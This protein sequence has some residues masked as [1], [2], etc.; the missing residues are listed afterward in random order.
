MYHTMKKSFTLLSFFCFFITCFVE[1]QTQKFYT[2]DQGLSNSLIN[3]IYQDRK[4]FVW[5][6]T[7]WGLNK[8]DGNKFTVYTYTAG[9]ANSLSD[10]YVRSI[11]EDR[12]GRLYVGLINGLMY[13]DPY[14]D[15]FVAVKMYGENQQLVQ[16]H[17][18]AMVEQANGD[19]IIA[20]SGK[21][22]FILRK[23]KNF[24]QYYASLS[25]RLN[26]I[27]IST[28]YQDRDKNLWIA[29]E[30]GGL[31][32]F[33]VSTNNLELISAHR[34]EIGENV[35][36]IVEDNIGNVF[37]GTL[38]NGLFIYNKYKKTIS[39]AENSTGLLVK[40]L[41]LNSENEL[42]IGT[43]GQG[44]K[45]YDY[46]DNKI[47]VYNIRTF[48][49]DITNA[50]V[51]SIVE[52]LDK[53]L[54]LGLFQKGVIFLSSAPNRFNYWGMKQNMN[55]PIGQG[56]VMS[57]FKDRAGICWV[58]VDN[59]GLYAVDEN[60][61]MIHHYRDNGSPNSVSNIIL[62]IFE[63]R[64]GN[65]WLGSFTS[66]LCKIDKNTGQCVY[67]PRLKG[68]KVYF[69]TEDKAGDLLVATYG[70][71]FYRINPQTRAC[72]QFV[73]SKKENEDYKANELSNDWINVLLCD[74]DGIIWVGHHKGLS[75]YN[76]RKKTFVN[77]LG[78]N[79][80]LPNMV[81]V[82]LMEASDGRI[83]VGTTDGFVIFDKKRSNLVKYTSKD[84]LPNN[85]ICGMKEDADGEVWISTYHGLS[86]FSPR[87]K[88]FVNYYIDDG[89][90]GYEFTRGASFE[91]A[92]GMIYFGGT[93]GL[94]FF[95]PAS[96]ISQQRTL[97]LLLTDLYIGN[98]RAHISRDKLSL[99]ITDRPIDESTEFILEDNENSFSV[100]L[101]TM[102][103]ANSDR[104]VYQY[105]LEGWSKEWL[106]TLPGVNRVSFTNLPSGKYV[107]KV[108]AV[109]NNAMSPERDFI[110]RILPPWYASWWAYLGYTILVLIA[111]NGVYKYYSDKMHYKAELREQ[112]K[113]REANESRLQYFIN[114]S[115]E[116]RTPMSLIISP[117]EKLMAANSNPEVHKSYLIIHRN[118]SR[119]LRLIN[120]LMDVRKLDKGQMHLKCRKTDIVG[121]IK[122][123]ILTF[124]YQ[125]KKK[126][127]DFIFYYAES[128][129]Y[130]WIDLNNFDKV[131]LNLFSNAFK[132]TP[133]G[134]KIEV[135]LTLGY[136]PNGK[137]PL[138]NYFQ[139]VV[140][141]TG[142][143]ISMEH[144]E[145]IFD[146]FY[147]V[148]I[149]DRSVTIGTG[150]G[151][152]LARQLV[153]LHSGIIYAENRTDVQGSR[154]IVRLP[155]G[156]SHLK[157][158]EVEEQ[159]LS[160][161]DQNHRHN[162]LKESSVVHL[163]AAPVKS[164]KRTKTNY[165]VL[166]VEDDDEIRDYLIAELSPMYKMIE[167]RNG[168]AGY[169]AILGKHPDLVVS[170]IMM[171]EMD[172]ITLCRKVKQNVNINHIPVILLTAKSSTEDRYEGLEIGADAYV[173]KPFHID[174]LIHQINNIVRNREL[175]KVKYTGLQ[176]HKDMLPGIQLKSSD[177]VLLEKV[178]KIIN[179]N[180]SNPELNV[181][182]L[183]S[184]VGLS[185]VHMHRKLKEL[186]NIS[187]RDLIRSIRL[188]QAATL[189]QS[190]KLG[191]SEVAYAT[192]FSNLS[193]F[194]N[195]FREFYGVSPSAY[196]AMHAE[197]SEKLPGHSI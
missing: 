183:A 13:Y 172:G 139:I 150:V 64:A 41:Y 181:E 123:L 73:S 32:Y 95:D 44:L 100:E 51:H 25:R 7:E 160:E 118:A 84:G 31:Y 156:Y 103:F 113:I 162:L 30:T 107:F 78:R 196:V 171:P 19:M 154:F 9:D 145:K 105:K 128:P 27:F 124:D 35:S 130:V 74:R 16:T 111:I 132:F 54:W 137:Y 70:S 112:E 117:L 191:I 99:N 88:V 157:K 114:I 173:L 179:S 166:I 56:S 120:Q 182:M 159:A 194:S 61:K 148:D 68:Q 45:M 167:S 58:G 165:T 75:C 14:V 47:G 98:H 135:N 170:D 106:S 133:D 80:L 175:L 129:L 67:I 79:N 63:D 39:T 77:Y 8:Y 10:N 185:R 65:L 24:A 168:R 81:V 82:S 119:I 163:D 53:N 197:E 72:E 38:T 36:A 69:I 60:G 131:M 101:S 52:D 151:L 66:G 12:T 136:D 184:G 177:E 11:F 116:I 40:S 57:I 22:V 83:W 76:P 125:A 43:D 189:L 71:G 178:M 29:S 48:P 96:I 42:L 15:S 146:R 110:I 17:V 188:K 33:N 5:I 144:I 3:Q 176:D 115:H 143:G 89:I 174:D 62:S 55:N 149:N 34:A 90:Q 49:Y 20:T 18:T 26:S 4:G 21:G 50:K 2:T 153:T 158:E 87:N 59:E 94:T 161:M 121:F 122:D 187:A 141:D 1:A 46:V 155:Y 169:E 92:D 93:N 152:H 186:M 142:V 127:I 86:K 109:D 134:G 190:K 23:G 195:V 108:K 180:I 147:Q 126:N 164:A 91:D 28:L 102:D 6:A 192:G 37:I 193:H 138:D 97:Q 85:L 104:V 140:S